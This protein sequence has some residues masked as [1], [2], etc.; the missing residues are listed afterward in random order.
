MTI[1]I[2][3]PIYYLYSLLFFYL[4]LKDIMIKD[5]ARESTTILLDLNFFISISF[6]TKVDIKTPNILNTKN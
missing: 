6:H 3:T 4:Y 2:I 1:L 5:I